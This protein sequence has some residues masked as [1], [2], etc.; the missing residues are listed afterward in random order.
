[1]KNYR[2][3]IIAISILALLIYSCNDDFMERYPLDDINDE[4]FWETET[5]L[6]LYCNN[7]YATYIRGFSYDWAYRSMSPWGYNEATIPYGDAITDNAAPQNYKKVA[8]NEY[9][10]YIT[11]ASGSGGWNFSDIRRLNYFLDNYNRGDIEFDKI[12]AYLGEVYYFKAYDY[13]EKVKLFGDV[14]WLSHVVEVNSSEVMAA[15]TPRAEVM[16]S[17]LHLMNMAIEYL[18]VKGD[19]KPGR[20]NR[21]VALHLKTRIGLYEG[22]YRKY[23]SDLGLDGIRFLNEAASACE[24]LMTG[25]YNLYESASVDDDYNSLFAQYSYSGNSEIILWKDYSAD[26]NLGAAFSRYYTQNLREK[27][28]ATRSLIDEYLC[29]DGKPISVSPLFQGKDSIQAEML[30]RDPRLTQT[31]CRFGEYALASGVMGANNT[32]LPNLPGLSGNKCPT[33]Y[34]IAKWW[35]NDP[36]DWDRVTRGEQACPI[37]RYAEVLLNYAEAKYELGECSQNVIDNTV[38]VIRQRVNMPALSIDNIPADPVMDSNYS[39]YCDYVPSPLLRE[40][41]RERRIELAFENFRWDDL[42]RWKA[43]KFLEIPVEGMKF[44]QNQFPTVV[45]DKDIYLSSEGYIMPY[46]QTLPNGRAFDES[47]QYLFPIPMEDLVLNPNLV[48]NPGWNSV[49]Q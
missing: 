11:G 36:A 37:F 16:D 25:E 39:R 40:I 30:N 12:K 23:H 15:R 35:L 7:F 1:M 42:M 18:P 44:V 32:P 22:T 31:I 14:P 8:A 17:V 45:V 26:D 13:F 20:I 46:A 4:N 2:I 29:A 41:R 21:D 3:K 33:G 19:E 47:K 49:A 10:G 9:I 38:N 43:G 5:D 6:E 28:G 48:Q 34:R 24:A 27:W